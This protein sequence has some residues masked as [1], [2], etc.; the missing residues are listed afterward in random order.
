[1]SGSVDPQGIPR[2]PRRDKNLPK[3]LDPNAVYKPRSL[4]KRAV[5]RCPNCDD[6]RVVIGAG[7]LAGMIRTC[8]E[9][10]LRTYV[11]FGL[12]RPFLKDR[13]LWLAVISS[14]LGT[15]IFS[16]LI[17]FWDALMAAPAGR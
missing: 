14:V 5:Y 2:P 12:P 10:G 1:M 4:P 3:V 9:C 6:G 15:L 17:F 11:P 13:R 8:T 16:A 7:V